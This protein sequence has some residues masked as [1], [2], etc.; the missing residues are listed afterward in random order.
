VPVREA[1]AQV[2]RGGAGPSRSVDDHVAVHA[3]VGE[4]R[5]PESLQEQLTS[6]SAAIGG[7]LPPEAVH[8]HLTAWIRLY[9][10]LRTEVLHQLDC[11][12]SD[13]EPVFE[14]CL[15]DLARML[16]LDVPDRPSR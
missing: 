1:C 16:A 10:L 3:A 9:G 14:Y 6:Y 2:G 7:R 5:V 13:L 12:F 11:A 8:V 4:R 15:G